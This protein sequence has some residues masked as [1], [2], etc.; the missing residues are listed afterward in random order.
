MIKVEI[1]NSLR[2]L[3]IS[4]G[5]A[6]DTADAM[7]HFV[8]FALLV[9]IAFTA[10]LICRR[11]VLKAV[12]KLVKKTKAT[13]DDVVFDHRVM[14]RLSH[15]VVPL[16]IYLFVPIAFADVDKV[17][18]SL[19]QRICQV[20]IILSLLWFSQAFLNA[21]YSV[22]SEM[23]RFKNRPLKGLLQTVQVVL[24]CVGVIIIISVLID[25][26]PLSLLAGLSA[27]SAVAMLVFKDS[28][29]GFVSG[30][31][32]SANNMLKVGDWIKMPKNDVDGIVIEVTLAT[33]KVRNWDNTISTVPP[34]ALVGDSFQNWNAMRESGG[35]RIKRSVNIDMNT[36]RFCTPEMLERFRK[37]GLL[38]DYLDRME[39]ET[40]AYNEERGTGNADL[41]GLADGRHLTNLGV[42]RAYLVAYLRSLPVTN[43]DLHCMVRQLQPT[44]HG[45]PLEIYFFS[46]VKEWVPY[47]G[48]QSDVFDH[49]LAIIP[50]FGLRV[51]QAPSG[52]DIAQWKK[53]ETKKDVPT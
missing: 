21:V 18:V 27:L 9:L 13:W 24:W 43:Q 50:E 26:D 35:R 23:E 53:N 20:L 31:Q 51:Y 49:V 14:V 16:T 4:M 33:V 2:K 12:A 7:D 19:I 47:E 17:T 52:W 34:Y 36:V 28:I 22:Y 5:I 6:P 45:I 1:L 38:K 25:K 10:D 39:Q 40:A 30:V 44:E 46:R 11:V 37:I 42:L 3:L 15:M 29:I 41:G 8:A 48:I 32:L